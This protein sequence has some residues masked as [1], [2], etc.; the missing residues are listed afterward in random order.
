MSDDLREKLGVAIAKAEAAHAR[1]DRLDEVIRDD[2]RDIRK[3]LDELNAHM[4][5]GKGW[6]AAVILL[7]GFA[8][9]GVVK[10]LSMIFH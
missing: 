3:V 2:L 7:S 1:I 9:A 5:K 6:A 8:G 10:L 4:N